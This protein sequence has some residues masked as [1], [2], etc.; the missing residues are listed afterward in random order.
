M[1]GIDEDGVGH[2]RGNGVRNAIYG[3]LACFVAVGPL[4]AEDAA[5]KV[6]VNDDGVSC[7]LSVHLPTAKTGGAPDEPRQLGAAMDAIHAGYADTCDPASKISVTIV[8]V[9]A[10]DAYGQANWNKVTTYGEFSI[11]SADVETVRHAEGSW[12]LERLRAVFKRVGGSR[13]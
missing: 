3:L 10:N 13:Q 6:F 1:R 4:S 5:N 7:V 8:T 11:S 9:G 12:P 2:R